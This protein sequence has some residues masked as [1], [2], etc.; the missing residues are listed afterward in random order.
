[1]IREAKKEDYDAV[2]NL[3]NQLFQIHQK[4][5][6]EL[7]RLDCPFT[8]KYFEYYL[9]DEDTRIFVYEE[10][11]QIVG[12]CLTQ[13]IRH[14]KH[15]MYYDMV[16]QQINDLFVDKS[17]RGRSVG[18]QL[19]THVEKYAKEIGAKKLE[20]D[21]WSFN[22]DA[23]LFYEKLKMNERMLRLELHIL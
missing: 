1:M 14:W 11:G 17:V 10:G 12:Y 5:H 22:K 7:I 13:T 4:N 15:Y 6:P 23:R 21:V 19:F 8:E 9:S 20:V 3:A 16:I 18:Y 2:Y